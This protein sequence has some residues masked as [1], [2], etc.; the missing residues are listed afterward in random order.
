MNR[1]PLTIFPGSLPPG[2]LPSW[3]ICLARREDPP[4][5]RPSIQ[6]AEPPP[7]P[8][9]YHV[10]SDAIWEEVDPPP[11]PVDRVSDTRL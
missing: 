9:D 2:S 5:S 10:T 8:T 7:P 3:G 4:G 1:P 11:P 6:E